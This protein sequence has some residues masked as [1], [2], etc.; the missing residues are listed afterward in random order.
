[1]V[2][3]VKGIEMFG[4][5]DNV[6]YKPASFPFFLAYCLRSNGFISRNPFVMN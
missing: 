6:V 5:L 1:M 4:S 2:H 3:V